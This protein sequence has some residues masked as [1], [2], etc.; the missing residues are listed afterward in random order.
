MEE[1]VPAT[2]ERSEK[3]N[4]QAGA[5]LR[6]TRDPSTKKTGKNQNY[7]Q[8]VESNHLEN[9][10]TLFWIGLRSSF[11]KLTRHGVFPF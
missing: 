7:S 1:Q 4:L 3:E 11:F 6:W 10:I 9:N 8:S 5:T 2:V